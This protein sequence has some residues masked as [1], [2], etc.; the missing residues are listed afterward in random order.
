MP[1]AFIAFERSVRSVA[2]NTRDDAR[3]LLA[4]APR[5]PIR[6]QVTPFGLSQAPQALH[7]LRHDAVR[8]AAVLLAGR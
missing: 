4:L 8:G 6:T 2:N 1:Y 7:E 3:A 5:I